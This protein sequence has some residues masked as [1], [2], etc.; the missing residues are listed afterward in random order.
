MDAS[1]A[2][3][4]TAVTLLIV[5]HAA[6]S[7]LR[8]AVNSALS[9]TLSDVEVL[10]IIPQSVSCTLPEIEPASRC[11]VMRCPQPG[12]A[13]ALN[14]GMDLA[15]GEYLAFLG[16]DSIADANFALWLYTQALFE[17][18]ELCHGEYA[19]AHA[20]Q[21]AEVCT[22]LAMMSRRLGSALPCLGPLDTTLFARSLITRL[23][24]RFEEQ[25]GCGAELVFFAQALL[26]CRHAA[27]CDARVSR[28]LS[29]PLT[30]LGN[31][32]SD[33]LCAAYRQTAALLCSRQGQ[34]PAPA[35]AHALAFLITDLREHLACCAYAPDA[36]RQC[37]S[38]DDELQSGCPDVLR[39]LLTEQIR[40]LAADRS[41]LRAPHYR[42]DDQP[43]P[44]PPPRLSCMQLRS[45]HSQV[46][47]ECLSRIGHGHDDI[48]LLLKH[49]GD[50]YA[51]LCF[52]TALIRAHGSRR[53][54]VAVCSAQLYELAVMTRPELHV[55]RIYPPQLAAFFECCMTAP[56]IRLGPWRLIMYRNN[57]G[58]FQRLAFPVLRQG[59][60]SLPKLEVHARYLGCRMDDIDIPPLRLLPEA[61]AS[62]L[63]KV[64]RSGLNME[65][66]AL[67]CPES[68]SADLLNWGEFWMPLI[69]GLRAQGYDIYVNLTRLP[70]GCRSDGLYGFTLGLAEICALAWRAGRIIALR[71]GLTELLAQ[72]PVP[73]DVIYTIP[74]SHNT[75]R[76]FPHVNMKQLRE[77]DAQA[78]GAQKC[79]ELVLARSCQAWC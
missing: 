11:R 73:L 21:A 46:L 14:M 45:I 23:G 26:H 27:L 62:A 37:Q 58:H 64:R 61:V 57:H 25:Y 34:L 51:V 71:S 33:R 40:H 44:H 60:T 53:P 74:Q 5:P 32:Q 8:T 7:D 17:G 18:A 56:E 31:A 76:H 70:P 15:A 28:H 3:A 6:A 52:I 39:S 50:A 67:L 1:P 55:A 43:D 29:R 38:L 75:L 35:L 77:Y 79:L 2:S 9:Q 22:D 66:F 72:S 54:V 42:A 16:E 49:I 20:A 24:L 30:A 47:H 12:R 59:L 68:Y 78:L 19:P 63:D 10:V 4:L 36:A 13:A 65:R 48:Y 69:A 41:A